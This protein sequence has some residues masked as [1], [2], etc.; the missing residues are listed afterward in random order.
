MKV[1]SLNANPPNRAVPALELDGGGTRDE[2]VRADFWLTWLSLGDYADFVWVC[3]KSAVFS[4]IPRKPSL[5]IV[6]TAL[7]R[8]IRT[9]RS[10]LPARNL[11]LQLTRSALE[12][13]MG[14]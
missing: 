3:V 10:R 6:I 13:P 7:T 2:I 8:K 9:A 14:P 1:S 11:C 4:P 5:L 12:A